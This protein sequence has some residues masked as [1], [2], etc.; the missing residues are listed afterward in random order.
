MRARLPYIRSGTR[1]L[2]KR[3]NVTIVNFQS[4]HIRTAIP[5]MIAIGC[6]KRSLL[7]LER[8][9]CIMRVLFVIWD[10]R[11][12]DCILLKKSID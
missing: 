10:M 3:I 9:V 5:L 11:K 8:A 12:P 4:I 6:L 2:G 1:Q 7:T